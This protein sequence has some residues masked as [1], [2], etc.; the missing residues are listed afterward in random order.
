MF[1]PR[2]TRSTTGGAIKIVSMDREFEMRGR[3]DLINLRILDRRKKKTETCVLVREKRKI[4]GS[5][6]NPTRDK[7]S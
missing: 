7:K 4:L 5:G 6:W 2:R 1:V 3:F